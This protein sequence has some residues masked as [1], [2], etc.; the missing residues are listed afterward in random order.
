[1]LSN[2]PK[3]PRFPYG[4]L[5]LFLAAVGT[6]SWLWMRYSYCWEMTPET[7]CAVIPKAVVT[8]TCVDAEGPNGPRRFPGYADAD[9]FVLLVGNYKHDKRT[10]HALQQ[11]DSHHFTHR[12][13]AVEGDSGATAW[14]RVEWSADIPSPG[15][16]CRSTARVCA[17]PSTVYHFWPRGQGSSELRPVDLPILTTTAE[18]LVPAST[19]GLVVAGAISA[20]FAWVLVGWRRRR[21]AWRGNMAGDN[22]GVERTDDD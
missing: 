16:P 15:S 12:Y 2:P 5:F 11:E 9:R 6:A 8:G 3:P 4:E 19:A 13:V 7:L 17:Y 1:M 22:P 10:Q 14:L 18:R 21:R 20:L